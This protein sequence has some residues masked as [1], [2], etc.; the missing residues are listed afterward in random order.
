MSFS[1][2]VLDDVTGPIH[3]SIG[4][5]Q[6]HTDSSGP[7]SS[8]AVVRNISFSNIH[9]TVTTDPAPLP[10]YP[11][12]SD[13][14]PGEGHSC[15]TLN[16]I[17]DTV[18]ENITF[19]NVHLTFGGGGTAEEGARRDLPQVAGEYFMLGPMPAYGLYAR[20]ARGLTLQ[21]VRFQV[22]KPDLRP[23]VIFDHVEDAAV[24]GLSVQGNH[25]AESVLRLIDSK[26][27]LF[28]ATRLLTPAAVFLEVDGKGN[29]G[30]SVDGGD[31]SKA[32]TPIVYKHGATEKAVK[33]R[34]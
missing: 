11:F 33:V 30:I 22:S 7:G 6:R 32:D 4:P 3:I 10:D 19:D 21:N 25:E 23:A 29:E 18:L 26:Q 13:Y 24:N 27:L 2:I 14:R 12:K 31:M 9:G 34:L 8:P 1:N 20:N 16:S 28:T 15:I 17:G 5:S